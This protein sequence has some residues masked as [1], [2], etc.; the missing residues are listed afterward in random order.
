LWDLADTWQ[1]LFFKRPYYRVTIGLALLSAAMVMAFQPTA[2]DVAVILSVS[3]LASVALSLLALFVGVL[4]EMAVV[5]GEPRRKAPRLPRRIS[6]G[7]WL[8]QLLI[9]PGL[10]VAFYHCWGLVLAAWLLGSWF[11]VW[12]ALGV[13]MAVSGDWI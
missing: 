9:L 11:F 7:A 13:G 2:A 10:L 12:S 3:L 5:P 4:W 8:C 1:A 6:Q